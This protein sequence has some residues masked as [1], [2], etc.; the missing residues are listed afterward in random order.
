MNSTVYSIWTSLKI[1]II[2]LVNFNLIITYK[3]G[4][5]R[6]GATRRTEEESL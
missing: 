4:K 3:I 5:G 1:D 2:A 6:N